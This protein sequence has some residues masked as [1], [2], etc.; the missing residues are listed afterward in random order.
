MKYNIEFLIIEYKIYLK[1]KTI[2]CD[3]SSLNF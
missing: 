1:Y 2:F 3:I